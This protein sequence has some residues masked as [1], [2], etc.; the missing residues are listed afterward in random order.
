MT[1]HFTSY[2]T[3]V[4]PPRSWCVTRRAG[5]SRKPFSDLDADPL[6]I[7]RWFICCWPI[8]SPRSVAIS[9]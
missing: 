1:G 2:K 7:L 6:D 8:S 4:E 3:R 9:A 5:S